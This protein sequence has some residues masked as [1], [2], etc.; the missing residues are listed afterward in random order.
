MA[1]G[2][3]MICAET[4]IQ[5]KQK[6]SDIKIVGALPCKNQDSKW[7]PKY[8]ERYHNLLGQL[9]H[10]RCLYNKFNGAECMMERNRYMVN[11]SSLMIALFNGT[12]GGTQQT[13][14]YARQQG[15]KIVFIN[16]E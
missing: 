15:L 11:N 8:R 14:D 13:I 4:V 12:P 5:L 10:I 9:D 3:D 2:F 1:I 7:P 16:N 6:Y